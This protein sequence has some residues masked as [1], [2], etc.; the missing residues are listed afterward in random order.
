MSG[1]EEKVLK[2]CLVFDFGSKDYSENIDLPI[3]DVV[4]IKTFV[5]ISPTLYIVK[6]EQFDHAYKLEQ[7]AGELL[8]DKELEQIITK[9]HFLRTTHE[10]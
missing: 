7:G 3:L 10:I 4:D 2:V 9:L 8:T 5:S 1:E 6:T